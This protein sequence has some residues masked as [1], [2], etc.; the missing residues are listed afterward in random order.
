VPVLSLKQESLANCI[1][2][3]SGAALLGSFLA[4]Y[5][6]HES[7]NTPREDV[8]FISQTERRLYGDETPEELF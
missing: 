1:A 6:A 8:R 2:Q 3:L 4:A 5:C 7:I